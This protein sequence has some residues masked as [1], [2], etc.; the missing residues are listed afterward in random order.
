[1][2]AR[3]VRIFGEPKKVISL[4]SVALLDLKHPSF[5]SCIRN[6]LS[7]SEPWDI[8]ATFCDFSTI[9]WFLYFMCAFPIDCL[10][11]F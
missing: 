11:A 10:V 7:S 9:F 3:F 4:V 8:V 6:E 2:N 5:N 1:M